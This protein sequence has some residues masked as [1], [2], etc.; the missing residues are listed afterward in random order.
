MVNINTVKASDIMQTKVVTLTPSTPIQSAIET[1]EDLHISGAP[2]IDEDGMI[3]GMLTAMDIA[4]AEHMRNDVIQTEGGDYELIG[5]DEGEEEPQSF[6][7]VILSLNDFS[8]QTTG[9][10]TVSDWMSSGIVSV[11][12]D[13]GLR[14]ICRLMVKEH[15]HRVPV[16]K[17]RKLAGI[18]STLDIV[19]CIADDSAPPEEKAVPAR[20]AS[21]VRAATN[22]KVK[23]RS[24]PAGPQKQR[25]AGK[26]EKAGRG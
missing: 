2:V 24:V 14:T 11:G 13:C 8:P 21:S 17:N 10:A 3:V 23:S 6:D 19:R 26:S 12:P 16:I 20:P 15:I 7:E 5:M 1:F 25:S 4:K 9:R 18:I 22:G